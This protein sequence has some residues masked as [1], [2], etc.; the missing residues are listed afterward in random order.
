MHGRGAVNGGGALERELDEHAGLVAGEVGQGVALAVKIG[1][2]LEGAG[3]RAVQRV[4][5]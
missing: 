5:A 1:V 2:E 4:P 3:E